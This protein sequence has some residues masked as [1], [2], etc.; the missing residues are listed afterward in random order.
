MV[1]Q[2]SNTFRR[3]DP[4]YRHDNCKDM[5]ANPELIWGFSVPPS[6]IRDG[7]LKQRVGD[8]RAV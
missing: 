5:H 8:A 1:Y 6:E 2:R 7:Q 4:P 3:V